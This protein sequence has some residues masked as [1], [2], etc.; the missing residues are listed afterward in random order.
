MNE[1]KLAERP[2]TCSTCAHRHWDRCLLS[3]FYLEIERKFPVVCGAQ[4][5]GWVQREPLLKRFQFWLYKE[6]K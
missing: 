1:I 3:G 2:K 5:S 4:F 6:S